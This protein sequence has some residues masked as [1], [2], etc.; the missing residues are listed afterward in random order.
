MSP[1]KCAPLRINDYKVISDR[2]L[3]ISSNIDFQFF[4]SS[5]LLLS[6]RITIYYVAFLLNLGKGGKSGTIISPIVPFGRP[7][8]LTSSPLSIA[9]AFFAAHLCCF[10]KDNVC[11][12]FLEWMYR[13]F[14]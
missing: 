8:P 10:Q 14:G 3:G 11:R 6:Y 4:M 7:T 1:T 12:H 5:T 9:S 13:L 2:L